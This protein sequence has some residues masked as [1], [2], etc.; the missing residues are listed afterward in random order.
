MQNRAIVIKT[1]G[2]PAISG[3][4]ADGIAAILYPVNT[5]DEI[6]A[7]KAECDR[8]RARNERLEA[9]QTVRK[10][11]DDERWEATR[12]ELA[13]THAIAYHGPIYNAVLIGWAMLWMGIYAIYNRL[14]AW[15]RS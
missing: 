11:G 14:S 3:A 15:N 5:S 9:K 2:D 1:M 13:R 7:I 12:A 8:L 6:A 4:L 10:L